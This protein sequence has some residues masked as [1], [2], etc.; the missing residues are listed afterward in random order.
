[1]KTIRPFS[2]VLLFLCA[3]VMVWS[4]NFPVWKIILEAP[5]YPEG[6]KMEIW[7]HKIAGDV[8][9]INGLNHYIGMGVILDENFPELKIIPYCVVI[10]GVLGLLVAATGKRWVLLCFV[11][12]QVIFGIWGMYRFW[13]WEYEYGHNLDPHAAIK[14]P[15][16]S[17]QPP[18]FGWKE[19]L[20]FLAGSFP[21]I[22]GLMVIIPSVILVLV[23]GYEQFLRKN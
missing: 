22:G 11:I 4:L 8:D 19:L 14:I 1:M 2:R 6:L 7:S 17:Y 23:W 15:G 3:V 16:M 5:Q 21:D 9:K 13:F 12:Y 10:M 18:L 20:N